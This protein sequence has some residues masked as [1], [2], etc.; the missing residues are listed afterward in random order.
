MFLGYKYT[1]SPCK[2]K[3]KDITKIGSFNIN[4]NYY[5]NAQK[6]LDPYRYSSYIQIRTTSILYLLLLY[7]TYKLLM[8]QS[9][10]YKQQ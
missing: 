8:F 9:I 7:I 5:R 4:L 3:N 1:P 2:N 6:L 10:I